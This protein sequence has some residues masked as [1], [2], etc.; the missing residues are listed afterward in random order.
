MRHFNPAP[1]IAVAA[2]LAFVAGPAAAH[3]R[4]VSATPA[5]NATVAATRTVSLTFSERVALITY[6]KG[7]MPGQKGILQKE[8]IAAIARYIELFRE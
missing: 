3:A 5:P 4:L 8:E 1:F 7:T 2:A 6:G